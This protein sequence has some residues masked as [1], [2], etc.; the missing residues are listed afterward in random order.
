L[1][2]TSSHSDSKDRT[3]ELDSSS[4]LPTIGVYTSHVH[5]NESEIT[6]ALYS[7]EG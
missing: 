2:N 1:A 4:Y 7:D 3:G 6:D 5:A